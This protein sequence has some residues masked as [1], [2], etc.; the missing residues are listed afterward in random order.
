MED[1]VAVSFETGAVL[2]GFF[3]GGPVSGTNREGRPICEKRG[4]TR[5]TLG[6]QNCMGGDGRRRSIAM[7]EY[8]IF[9]G[10]GPVHCRHPLLLALRGVLS[11]GF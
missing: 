3:G 11:S 7:S 8:E 10:R 2:I 9:G 5:L 4:R 6:T 1:A